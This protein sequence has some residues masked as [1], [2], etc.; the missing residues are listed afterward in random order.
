MHGFVFFFEE[1]IVSVPIE[2]EG[3][4]IRVSGVSQL[5]RRSCTGTRFLSIAGSEVPL[6]WQICR[7]C[8][9][10]DV[11]FSSFL[12]RQKQAYKPNGISIVVDCDNEHK[13]F[14][15]FFCLPQTERAV[16]RGTH[17]PIGRWGEHLGQPR[18]LQDV[19]SER[20]H[21]LYRRAAT[22]GR[23]GDSRFRSAVWC[24]G[25]GRSFVLFVRV[26][27][28]GGWAS[29]AKSQTWDVR[30]SGRH[31]IVDALSGR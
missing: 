28:M 17:V 25:G 3:L 29:P 31:V 7:G 19:G 23:V 9:V 22:T 18:P 30:S 21:D 24:R 14:K 11:G 6:E 8:L 4:A 10:V 16:A 13:E 1:I 5:V 12:I 26:R 27:D 15:S 2:K 20:N